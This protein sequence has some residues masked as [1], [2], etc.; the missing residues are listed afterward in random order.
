MIRRLGVVASLAATGVALAA[1]GTTNS[2]SS[3]TTS[4]GAAASSGKPF[5][6]AW[7]YVGST[8]DAGW[9]AAHDAGRK[10]VV[11]HLG[12][13]VQTT[14]KENVPE[15]PQVKQVIE[16]LVRDGNKV[17][18][19]TSFGYQPAMV[20]EAAAHPDVYFEQAT[21]STVKK[22]L[23]EYYG[24]GEDSDYLAGMAAGAASKKGVLGFVSPFP[25]PEVIREVNAYTLGAQ[26]THPGAQVKVVWTNTWFDPATESK[27]A[28]SL[29][30]AGA[31]VLG[32]G[33]DSPATGAV[34]KTAGLKWTGY[35]SNQERFAPA[36][37]L[38]GAVYN[39]GPYYLKRI[40]AAMNGTWTTGSY[41]GSIADGFTDIAPFGVSVPQSVR[42]KIDA[43]R[44]ALVAGKF[45]EF[46]GPLYDQTGK[47]RLPAGQKLSL[48]DILGITWFVKGVIGKPTGA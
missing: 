2:S 47:L 40:E 13:K 10:Y 16:N 15:G 27:A 9:T 38:T 4:S 24:A 7:I 8:A 6:V 33:Q 37:W 30:S 34:A 21:G 41:Y 11:A 14:F 42:T 39:W 46:Q 31:D 23:A 29:V 36:Q 28:Q 19:A 48:G 17:I 20:A 25:I 35:D 3:G 32:Q 18:F 5:K 1:C 43:Q 26:T 44:T 22:N 12:S 45:Y